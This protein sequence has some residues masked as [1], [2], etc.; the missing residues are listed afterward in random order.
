MHDDT[1][2]FI[3][4]TCA[5]FSLEEESAWAAAQAA[6]GISQIHKPIPPRVVTAVEQIPIAPVEPPTPVVAEPSPIDQSI[7]S[8]ERRQRCGECPGCTRE[9]C[10]VCVSCQVC[11]RPGRPRTPGGARRGPSCHCPPSTCAPRPRRARS[12]LAARGRSASAVSPQQSH[13]APK[14]RPDA[15][16][17]GRG[18]PPAS[19]GGIYDP[20][21]HNRPD[22]R[23]LHPSAGSPGRPGRPLE[24]LIT[25]VPRLRFE[26]TPPCSRRQASSAS[27]RTCRSRRT[28]AS[29]W[30]PS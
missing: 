7:K 25:A 9:D 17:R 23:A 27:A 30:R 24:P 10:G 22:R 11:S 3:N 21:R 13:D 2:A 16:R 6:T 19:G 20:S 26:P 15:R 4:P 28:S 8:K 1:P 12:S 14:A 29:A 18:P 5:S